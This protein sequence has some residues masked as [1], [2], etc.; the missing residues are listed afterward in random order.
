MKDLKTLVR[1]HLQALA[2]QA[3]SPFPAADGPRQPIALDHN[4]SPYNGPHNR[5]PAPRQTE[6]REALARVK[7]LRPEC[8][9]TGSGSS[10]AID[11][12]FRIF[13]QPGKDNVAAVAP[14][15]GLYAERAAINDVEYRSVELGPRFRFEAGK[16]LDTC[17]ART[18]VLFLCSP[19]SPTGQLL[20]RTEVLKVLER[21]DGM[22]VIDEAY[23][24]FSGAKSFRFELPR[25]GHLIVLQT[26]SAAWASAGIR[27][28]MA[29]ARP[30]VV[31]YFDRVALPCHV[32]IPTQ[33]CALDILRRRF[34]VDKWV[35]RLVEERERV[36]AAFRL[37]PACREVFPTDS[38]FFLA[39]MENADR[40][41]SYLLGK[42]IAAG[43]CEGMAQCADCLRFTV[44]SPQEN[45][46]LLGAL[47]QYT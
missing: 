16:L 46:A 27:L 5:Y 35:R 33:D 1:P 19:N 34:D 15:C 14:T 28:G 4:E 8:I 10:E 6:L 29:F 3:C 44:G 24:D 39:R 20:D 26:L 23:G 41:R 36:M 9:F 11:L 31:E 45:S 25:F 38:N 12:V 47:R 42:G 13:C 22:V 7:G 43:S 32:G 21:F 2:T 30:A 18:K 37:L 40:I 17:D